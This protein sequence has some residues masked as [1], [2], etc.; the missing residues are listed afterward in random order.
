MPK[1]I[2]DY[3]SFEQGLATVQFFN[4]GDHSFGLNIGGAIGITLYCRMQLDFILFEQ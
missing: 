3:F 4:T 2:A 1:W